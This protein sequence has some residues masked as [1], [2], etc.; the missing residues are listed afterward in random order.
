MIDEPVYNPLDKNHLAESI[1]REFFKRPLHALPPPETFTGAGIYALYYSGK[2]PLYKSISQSLK[3]VVSEDLS[4]SNEQPIP[5]YIGKS[6]P[7]GRRK[8]DFG[9]TPDSENEE[10]A[11]EI[12]AVRPRH[13]KLYERLK[14]HSISIGLATNLKITDFRCRYMLVDEVWVALGEAR[15]V[16]WF[17]P[18]WN[19]RIEGFGS[20]VE[21]GGRPGTA[22]SVWDILHSG[23]KENLGIQVNPNVETRI[24]SNLRNAKDT[25]LLLSAIKEH[26][27][28]KRL[29]RKKPPSTQTH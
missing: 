28:A 2:Y 24:V 22:R 25:R 17:K 20:N 16:D 26:R 27:D 3:A 9:E 15:L 18:V 1:V 8:G 10:N 29:F 11:K 6:D 23:R 12:L 4:K 7:P 5:I 14:K 13:R 19:I 21:G